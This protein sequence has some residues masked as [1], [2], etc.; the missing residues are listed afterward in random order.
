MSGT[1]KRHMQ[2]AHASGTRKHSRRSAVLRANQRLGDRFV[3]RAKEE[4]LHG[5]QAAE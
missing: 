1:R 3:T 5:R 2:A 4:Q